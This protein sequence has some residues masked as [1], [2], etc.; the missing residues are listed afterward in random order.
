MK[1]LLILTY[2]FIS[3]AGYSQNLLDNQWQFSLGDSMSWKE[4]GFNSASWKT[5]KSGR[6]WEEQG[7]ADYNGFAWYRKTVLIPKGFQKEANKQQG[8]ILNLGTIDDADQIYFNGKLLGATGKFPPDYIGAYD[9]IREWNID[10]TLILWGKE[11]LIAVRV[12]DETGGGGITGQDIT[13]KIK[14]QESGFSIKAQ[15]P[16]ENQLF[17]N[18]EKVSFSLFIGNTALESIEGKIEFHLLNDFNDTISSWNEPI[19]IASHK[20]KQLTIDKPRLAPGFYT[21]YADFKSTT[22]NLSRTF[23]FGVDPEKIVSPTDRAADFENFWMRAKKELTAVDPQFRL[24][25][26]DSLSTS[27]RDIYLL[28]MRS[29]DNVLIRGWYACPKAPGK[30]PAILHVQGYS[31]SQE[32]SWGY[33]GDDMAVLVLNVRGHGNSRD[34]VNPGFPGYLQYKLKDRER[35][36]YRGAYMDCIRAVD[37]LCSRPEV[38]VR[39]LVVEGGSQGGALSIATAALDNERVSLCIPA[40]PF[41]SDFPH[42]FKVAKWPGNK[43]VEFEK[44]NPDFGWKKI[45]ENLSYFDIKNLAPWVRCRVFMSMGLVDNVCPPHINFAAYNQLSV[46]KSYE[47]FPISGHGLPSEYTAIKY[48]WM[49]KELE[50]LKNET[51]K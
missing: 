6:I 14:G 41:L 49:K 32:L 4:P 39:Y 12:F 42:Y 7:F 25:R 48:N 16:R 2:L 38:D 19:N 28:E 30:F 9:K 51:S 15:F 34:D 27:K 43:F 33:P 50:K 20:N 47:V 21:L 13:L 45:Y 35:Y 22:F 18:D 40:V 46:P 44:N 3:I 37:F 31:S 26:N 5:I 29:L 8:M 23:N 1:R 36:I 17:I 24:T 11:N 10:P